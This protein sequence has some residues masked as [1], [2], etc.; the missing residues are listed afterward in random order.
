MGTGVNVSHWLSQSERRGEE[1]ANQISKKDFDKIAEM[2]FDHVRL[3]IDEE[4]FYDENL[5]RYED[6]FVLLKNAIDWTLENNMN[7]V[8][9]LHITRAHYFLTESEN[10]LFNL[11][12]KLYDTPLG[13]VK[14]DGV[15]IKALNEAAVFSESYTEGTG[16]LLQAA[17]MS[18]ARMMAV[19]FIYSWFSNIL[20]RFWLRFQ[21][22]QHRGAC[23]SIRHCA[24]Q[25]R[26]V[27]EE[28]GP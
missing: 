21:P 18:T 10:T 17:V 16:A 7:I 1:R 25:E 3:P 11:I 27:R 23:G 24:R 2:G 28:R 19:L 13:T 20:Q 15:N 8:I 6:A 12:T 4:Q 22:W 5:N 14:L 9:D 26:N